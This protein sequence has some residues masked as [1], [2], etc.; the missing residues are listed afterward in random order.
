MLSVNCP[1]H[2]KR[3]FRVDFWRTGTAATARHAPTTVLRTVPLP[4][5]AFAPW[6][7]RARLSSP[8][9]QRERGGPPEGWWR[10]RSPKVRLVGSLRRT[11]C[12]KPAEPAARLRKA[13][14]ARR[15]RRTGEPLRPRCDL[16][17]PRTPSHRDPQPLSTFRKKGNIRFWEWEDIVSDPPQNRAHSPLPCG[18][19]VEGADA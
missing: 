11:S 19:G 8:A 1:Q 18:G 13:K 6:G 4:H 10:G 14:R 3:A 15:R 16:I 7:R 9:R 5:S 12:L 2:G 17:Q